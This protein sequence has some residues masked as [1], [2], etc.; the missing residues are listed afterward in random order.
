MN[1]SG[2]GKSLFIMKHFNVFLILTV[3][4]FSVV[5]L[6]ILKLKLVSN[7]CFTG[8][9]YFKVAKIILSTVLGLTGFKL[10]TVG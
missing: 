4:I 9:F 7:K 3:D 2:I 6:Y 8:N 10:E 1:F 5:T